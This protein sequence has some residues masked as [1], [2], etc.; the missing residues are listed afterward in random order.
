MRAV[1]IGALALLCGGC[2]APAY[3]LVSRDPES[4]WLVGERW[5]RTES[6]RATVNTSYSRTYDDHL[7]FD[8]EVVNQA[9]TPLVVDPAQF[10]YTIVSSANDLPRPLRRRFAAEDPH[11]VQTRLD[12]ES[13]SEIGF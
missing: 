7:I 2:A 5:V 10:S 9:D 13:S 11:R 8:V 12:H 1:L 4:P 6:S 3:D